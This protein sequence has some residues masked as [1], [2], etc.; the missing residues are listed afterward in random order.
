M[1][2]GEDIANSL[3]TV[4][5]R[6]PPSSGGGSVLRPKGSMISHKNR[7]EGALAGGGQPSGP[8]FDFN[9]WFSEEKTKKKQLGVSDEH[10]VKYDEKLFHI[11]P[12]T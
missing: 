6:A 1:D 11:F 9:Q 5:E 3:L 4:V 7:G 8:K 10:L 2:A 12:D